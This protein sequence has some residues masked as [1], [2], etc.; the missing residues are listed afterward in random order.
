MA[1]ASIQRRL[2]KLEDSQRPSDDSLTI[3]I[4]Y[5]DEGPVAERTRGPRLSVVGGGSRT[6]RVA[7]GAEE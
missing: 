6:G 2:R 7:E 4:E 3:V 1:R 5:V